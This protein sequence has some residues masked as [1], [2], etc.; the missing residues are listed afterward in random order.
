MALSALGPEL[1]ARVKRLI[2]AAPVMLFLE[3]TPLEPHDSSRAAVEGLKSLGVLFSAYNVADN[4]DV[5][6]GVQAAAGASGWPVLFVE[7]SPVH[8]FDE[9]LKNGTLMAI[10]P[11]ESKGKWWRCAHADCCK[12]HALTSAAGLTPEEAI[13]ERCALIAHSAPVVVFMKGTV[14]KPRCGFSNQLLVLLMSRG[15]LFETFDILSDEFVRAGM[16]TYSNWPTFPQLYIS[17]AFIGGLDVVKVSVMAC[18]N[19]CGCWLMCARPQDLDAEQALLPLVPASARV[20]ASSDG[21][22]TQ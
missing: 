21:S 20:V 5:R 11:E 13:Q 12:A 14:E 22:N 15:V 19:C 9:R 8:D 4:A 17:G 18:R 6:R 7:G 2:A 16:K 3:G 1:E 10:V